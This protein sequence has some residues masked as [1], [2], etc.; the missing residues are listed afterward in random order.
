MVGLTSP[1][2]RGLV[3]GLLM[4]GDSGA[5]EADRPRRF[6]SSSITGVPSR[7]FDD[8]ASLASSDSTP[9]LVRTRLAVGLGAPVWRH[10]SK[11]SSQ[12]GLP[13]ISTIGF[14]RIS[15]S[16][17][18]H[19]KQA[20]CHNLPAFSIGFPPS[21]FASAKTGLWHSSQRPFTLSSCDSKQSR[22]R[23]LPS[24]VGEG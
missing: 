12:H 21:S 19:L 15:L 23:N 10:S 4:L 11:H 5:G 20:P 22:H 9:D 14:R 17:A 6:E 24:S 7:L 13:M 16:H 3:T 8:R 18:L 2:P 1:K